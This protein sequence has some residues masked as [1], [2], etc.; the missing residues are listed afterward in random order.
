MKYGHQHDYY[1][2]SQLPDRLSVRLILASHPWTPPIAPFFFIMSWTAK[3]KGMSDAEFLVWA[4]GLKPFYADF[5]DRLSHV[6]FRQHLM[7]YFVEFEG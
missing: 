5:I 6:T 7:R 2:P 4:L 1:I 3:K